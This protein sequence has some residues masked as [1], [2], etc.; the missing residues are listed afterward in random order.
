MVA[1]VLRL[2]AVFESPA[3]VQGVVEIDDPRPRERRFFRED[4]L[5]STR[6]CSLLIGCCLLV[7]CPSTGVSTF[8]ENAQRDWALGLEFLKFR[9]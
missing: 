4:A 1:M 6:V 7:D 2:I 8:H 9:N 3:R 5:R